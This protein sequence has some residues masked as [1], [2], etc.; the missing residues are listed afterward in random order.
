MSKIFEDK[1]AMP[2]K[3]ENIASALDRD[4]T[5]EGTPR[6]SGEVKWPDRE[7]HNLTPRRRGCCY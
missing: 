1:T 6:M 5:P 4:E 3:Y 2:K 7:V